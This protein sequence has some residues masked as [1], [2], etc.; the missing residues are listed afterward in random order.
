MAK[1]G[2]VGVEHV[3]RLAKLPIS[4]K[5]LSSFQEQLSEITEY[6]GRIAELKT[7]NLKRKTTIKNLKVSRKDERDAKECLTQEEAVSNTKNVHNGLFVVP[8]IFKE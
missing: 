2:R 3:A 6:V 7:K 1:L 8:A 4:S 5:E